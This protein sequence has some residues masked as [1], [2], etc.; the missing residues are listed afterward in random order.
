M[1]LTR[2]PPTFWLNNQHI[3]GSLECYVIF[4]H[5][6]AR[7]SD[8]RQK[9]TSFPKLLRNSHDP[10][11]Q[12][13]LTD[14]WPGQSQPYK[15]QPIHDTTTL[16]FSAHLLVTE[17]AHKSTPFHFG[18]DWGLLPKIGRISTFVIANPSFSG[19]WA[20]LETNN[21]TVLSNLCP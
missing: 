17:F 15:G 6:N 11:F 21:V 16:P 9:L 14:D 5:R 20:I 4:S 2:G 12:R 7:K 10:G 13:K 1:P 19:K 8:H 18:L 3:Q